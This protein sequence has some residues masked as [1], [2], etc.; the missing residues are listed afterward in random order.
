[1]RNGHLG[2]RCI[3]CIALAVACAGTPD[4]VLAA[5]YRPLAARDGAT[6]LEIANQA[7]PAAVIVDLGLPEVDG[8]QTIVRLRADPQRAGLPI[9]ALAAPGTTIDASTWPEGPTVV[10]RT[11]ELGALGDELGRWLPVNTGLKPRQEL[12]NT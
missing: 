6:A 2:N 9:L 8:Y 12:A 5:G 10:L 4:A 11:D 7:H 1:M 3:P